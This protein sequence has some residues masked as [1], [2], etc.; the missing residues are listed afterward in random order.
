MDIPLLEER[1]TRQQAHKL[2]IFLAEWIPGK[3][4]TQYSC[5][6]RLSAEV[7]YGS[8]APIAF[9]PNDLK[10]KARKKGKCQ[11]IKQG[12]GGNTTVGTGHWYAGI[13]SNHYMLTACGLILHG[14]SLYNYVKFSQVGD[15]SC[16]RL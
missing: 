4:G 5:T 1:R 13:M 8:K 7:K 11:Y 2:L 9:P 12:L 16:S 15:L 14:P 10:G 3:Q 6:V